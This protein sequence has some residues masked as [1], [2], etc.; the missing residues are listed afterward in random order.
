MVN[1]L[2]QLN[3]WPNY[4]LFAGFANKQDGCVELV[5]MVI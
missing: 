5:E 4:V 3:G 1:L 2:F